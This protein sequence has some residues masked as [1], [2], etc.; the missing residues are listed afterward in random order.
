[1]QADLEIF[2]ES[3]TQVEIEGSSVA[4]RDLADC[5]RTVADAERSIE[6]TSGCSGHVNLVTVRLTSGLT[7]IRCACG[8][9]SIEGAGDKLGILA[10]NIEYVASSGAGGAH[11][12][13]EHYEG[14]PYL[15]AASIPVVV[16]L[17]D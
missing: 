8:V 16:S 11:V 12:H 2:F 1:M 4:L 5:I 9:L 15:A 3:P 17:R 13:I 14:H 7:Q 10:D 6:V